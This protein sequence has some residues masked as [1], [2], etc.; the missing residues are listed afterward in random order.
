MGSRGVFFRIRWG[1]VGKCGGEW[2]RVFLGRETNLID[3]KGRLA[4]PARFREVVGQGA[5]LVL[6]KKVLDP[7]LEVYTEP[8]WAEFVANLQKLSQVKPAVRQYKRMVFSGAEACNL[9]RQGR[10]LI[11]THLREY[12]GIDPE[13]DR[14]TVLIANGATF[15]IWNAARLDNELNGNLDLTEMADTLADL[16]L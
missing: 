8:H 10:I 5:R 11:P 16:G 6:T 12:A 15:E 2:N 4:I 14:E 3:A 7:C 9:D 13:N 1:K